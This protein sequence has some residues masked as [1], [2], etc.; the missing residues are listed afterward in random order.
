MHTHV[1]SGLQIVPPGEQHAVVHF[2]K[3]AGTTRPFGIT[4]SQDADKL[5]PTG[6]NDRQPKGNP[7]FVS[8][9]RA[10]H[11]NFVE[12][13][14]SLRDHIPNSKWTQPRASP[15]LSSGV[16]N[17]TSPFINVSCTHANLSSIAFRHLSV[18]GANTIALGM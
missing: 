15:C 9:W 17:A 3:S 16:H 7:N 13:G 1:D 12:A 5:P 6:P 18:S 14:V 10:F 11:F 2:E 8:Q 4:V